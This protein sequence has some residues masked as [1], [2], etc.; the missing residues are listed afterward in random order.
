MPDVAIGHE[1]DAMSIADVM[2]EA[3]NTIMHGQSHEEHFQG[4]ESLQQQLANLDLGQVHGVQ[5]TRDSDGQHPLYDSRIYPTPTE[6]AFARCCAHST[7]KEIDE[8][9]NLLHDESYRKED[10]RWKSA[11]Q[12]KRFLA[13]TARR[14]GN[15]DVIETVITDRKPTV[16]IPYVF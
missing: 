10:L 6:N 4:W 9:L 3:W 16:V 14:L 7:D 11:K 5:Q 8:L 1:P 15:L 13:K 12:M 2:N